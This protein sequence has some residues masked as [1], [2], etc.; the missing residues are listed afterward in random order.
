MVQIHDDLSDAMAAP[1]NPD[2]MLGRASLPI[3]FAQVVDHPEQERFLALRKAIPDPDALAEAQAI[4]IRCGAVSYCID[5][6]LCRVLAAQEILPSISLVRQEKLEG[7][8][9]DIMKPVRNL[10]AEMGL[11]Q[12]EIL[13]QPSA[14]LT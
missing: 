13:L 12:P 14:P 8:L 6:L 4:L 10:F 2:W 9:S 11:K 1:A 3:L 5:Q 7:L